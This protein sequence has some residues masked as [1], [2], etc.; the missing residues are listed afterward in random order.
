M[1][2]KINDNMKLIERKKRKILKLLAEKRPI[3]YIAKKANVS[4]STVQK[5]KNKY[6]IHAENPSG[7]PVDMTPPSWKIERNFL[8]KDIDELK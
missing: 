2:K 5:Y 1:K 6:F 3:R 7:D 8:L 4:P